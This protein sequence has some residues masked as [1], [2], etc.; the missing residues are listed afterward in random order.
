ML[1][2]LGFRVQGGP[3]EFVGVGFVLPEAGIRGVFIGCRYGVYA[4]VTDT[5]ADNNLLSSG[6]LV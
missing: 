5:T 3:S 2:S 6:C 1:L 4:Q